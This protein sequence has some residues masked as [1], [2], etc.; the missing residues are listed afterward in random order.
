M[1]YIHDWFTDVNEK[2]DL[3]MVYH[4]FDIDNVLRYTNQTRDDIIENINNFSY[5]CQAHGLPICYDESDLLK[6]A[7]NCGMGTVWDTDEPC[8]D[9][10]ARYFVDYYSIFSVS[11]DE[12]EYDNYEPNQVG[13]LLDS[14]GLLQISEHFTDMLEII[15]YGLTCDL[16]TEE[17]ELIEDNLPGTRDVECMKAY[18]GKPFDYFELVG[19]LIRIPMFYPKTGL[20]NERVD[21]IFGPR[22]ASDFQ[23]AKNKFLNDISKHLS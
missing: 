23:D 18:N 2:Y 6:D 13:D 19:N 11:V 22:P 15:Y 4:P 10:N 21:R 17:R 12:Y 5:R 9:E 14:D 1:S 16:T 8:L 7:L 20:D 3:V